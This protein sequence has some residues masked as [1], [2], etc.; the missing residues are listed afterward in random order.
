MGVGKNGLIFW[1]EQPNDEKDYLATRTRLGA[2]IS[3]KGEL[4]G[5]YKELPMTHFEVNHRVDEKPLEVA[6]NIFEYHARAQ[7]LIS[8]P[9]YFERSKEFGK[10]ELIN[11]FSGKPLLTHNIKLSEGYRYTNSYILNN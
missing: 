1:P 3:H 2:L 8:R 5:V 6:T 9:V 7:A 4:K 11:I 10:V